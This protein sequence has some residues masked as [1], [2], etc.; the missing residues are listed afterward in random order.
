LIVE[1][2]DQEDLIVYEI[3]RNPVLFG[4]F[5]NNYDKTDRDEP[6]EFTWYQK[7]WLADFS[8]YM[9]VCCARAVGKTIFIVNL[10]VWMLVM[11]IFSGDSDNYIVYGVPSKVHL[12]SV[13]TGLIRSF[14]INSFL[15]MFIAHNAGINSNDHKITLLNQS[16]LLC[17]IAGQSGTGEGFV[18]LHAPVITFD[19]SGYFPWSAFTE[20]QPILNSFTKGCKMIVS[21]VPDGRREKSVCY[22]AD[23]ENSAYSKHRI[24][25]LQNPRFTD[26]DKQ[27]AIETY[28]GEQTEDYL[29]LVLGQ[30]GKPVFS[31]FD[32]S[33]MQF[34]NDNVYY[35]EVDGM[36]YQENISEYLTRLSAFP[37]LPDKSLKVFFGLDIGYTEPTAIVINYL[38]HQHLIHFHGRIRFNK[39]SYPIQ[40]KLIDYLDTRFDPIL[41]GIDKGNT[42]MGVIHHMMQDSAYYTKNYVKRVIPI[43]Y[44]SD[45]ILG[46]DQDGKEIKVDTKEFAVQVL[47]NMSND[48][49]IV[50]SHKDLEMVTEL[51]RMTYSKT[52]SG[53]IIYKTLTVRGGQRGEDHFTSALMSG[54]LAYYLEMEYMQSKAQK[55]KLFRPMWL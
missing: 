42:G 47:Q 21:G 7:E 51:E 39:V 28:G 29:H 46:V 11:N 14:R 24:S 13:W 53:N 19:E 27:K 3:L 1:K 5:V 31:L 37:G 33:L 25:A 10:Y 52:P 41:M 12:E 6:F 22:H 34:G 54:I 43:D 32:R 20:S 8:T 49:K 4:E 18:S 23:M 38:D 48:H 2:I 44:S 30:H 15:K 9:S 17:R 55:V 50:Y 40:E 26:S 45:I 16:S 36:K 35:L